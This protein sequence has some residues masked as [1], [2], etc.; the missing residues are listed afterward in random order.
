MVYD[1]G[2]RTAS[3]FFYWASRRIPNTVTKFYKV[4]DIQPWVEKV[5]MSALLRGL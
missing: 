4:E 3:G 2:E 1:S 5:S